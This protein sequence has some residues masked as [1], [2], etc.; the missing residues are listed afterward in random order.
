MK[1]FKSFNDLFLNDKVNNKKLYMVLSISF[2]ILVIY[3]KNVTDFEEIL[4]DLYESAKNL[5]ENVNNE[6]WEKIFTDLVID[7]LSK[8]KS[9]L[10]NKLVVL[11]EYVSTW[12]K[13]LSKDFGYDSCSVLIQF[14]KEDIKEE[15]NMNNMME[16]ENIEE[17]EENL[18]ESNE[19]NEIAMEEDD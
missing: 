10:E 1:F 8:G 19:D 15:V 16:N 17:N 2:L 5:S 13:K 12:M 11:N 9:K 18:E 7:I 6:D 4:A 14:L 3:L